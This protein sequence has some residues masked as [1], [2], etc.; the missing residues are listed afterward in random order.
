MRDARVIKERVFA[1]EKTMEARWQAMMGRR[2]AGF[3]ESR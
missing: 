3:P 2:K 1:N